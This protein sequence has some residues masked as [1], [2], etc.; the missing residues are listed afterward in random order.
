MQREITMRW[1]LMVLATTL[2]ISPAMAQQDR[3]RP[4]PASERREQTRS[5]LRDRIMER[6]ER[7]L[8]DFKSELRLTPEQEANWSTFES[9]VR[10]FVRLHAEQLS[11]MRS[12]LPTTPAERLRQRAERLAS[13]SSALKRLADVEEALYTKLTDAQKER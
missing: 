13:T 9:G 5:E 1:M 8:A 3:S 7:G 4:P 12:E 10:D 11:T 2:L 6:F